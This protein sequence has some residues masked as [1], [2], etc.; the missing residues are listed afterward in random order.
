[1]GRL[2]LPLH[3][4]Q[5]VKSCVPL[6]AIVQEIDD[7]DERREL[8]ATIFSWVTLTRL[9]GQVIVREHNVVNRCVVRATI[10]QN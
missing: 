8:Y 5:V 3:L 2:G 4:K 6:F 7:V 1:M 9:I 10:V